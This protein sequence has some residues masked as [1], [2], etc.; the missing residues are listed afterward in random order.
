MSGVFEGIGGRWDKAKTPYL[1]GMKAVRG[2]LKNRI[3]AVT[4]PDW[5]RIYRIFQD[6]AWLP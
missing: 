4:P 2:F 3:E 6:L 1:C 5:D